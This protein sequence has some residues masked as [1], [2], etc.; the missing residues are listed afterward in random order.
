M[1]RVLVS[2]SLSAEGVEILNSEADLQ[3]DVK[4]GLSPDELK[5]I[6]GDYHGL[7]IRSATKVTQEILDAADNLEVVGRAGIGVDNVDVPAATK[8]GVVVMNTPGGNTTTTAEHAVS[9][10]MSLIRN[11]PQA[12][13]SMKQGKWEK[14]KFQGHE[15]TGKTL[16]I[17]GL[18]A[19]GS[20]VADRA[21]GLKMKI[22][23]YDPFIT[24]ERAKKLGVE[25]VELDELYARADIIT[26]HVPKLKETT[27]LICKETIAKMKD[28]VYIVCAARGGIVNEDD[29]LEGLES[30]KVAGAALDVF[31]QEPPGDIPLLQ[32]PRLI[33]TPHL[34]ASTEEAQTAVAL[35]VADQ[36]S[37]YL[38]RGIIVNALN[39]PSVPQE[40]V[41]RMRPYIELAE[42]LG[43]FQAQL[44]VEGIKGIEIE[45]SGHA[46]QG[47]TALLTAAALSGLLSGVVGD[48]INL[49]NAPVAARERGIKIKETTASNG[50]DYTSLIRIR[51]D[52]TKGGM[53]LAGAIFGKRE[54][55]IVEIDGIAIE[56]IPQGNILVMNNYD[57]PGLVGSIGTTLGNNSINIGQLQFGRDEPG[58]RAITVV[59]VDSA[60]DDKTAN[61]LA[62]LPNVISVHRVTL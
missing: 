33:C 4:T 20:I 59:N 60:P 36:I 18:G 42:S 26:I 11:I 57:K 39:V 19:I 1:K 21:V 3:V 53:T 9:L 32:N 2:D 49:V 24:P 46:A 47:H 7:V 50:E 13:M 45:L 62:A 43:K 51:V 22:V 31:S 29:L 56:A 28:G 58:G 44:G 17:V 16:G 8:K 48:W 10:M 23:A 41:E 30:G 54:P 61:E 14:K 55:R 6:I 37:D 27:D 34:G 52:A 12:T 25:Q 38:V 35:Q 15:I 40:A 5:E